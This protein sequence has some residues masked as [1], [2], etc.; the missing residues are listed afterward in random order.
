LPLEFASNGTD[1]PLIESILFEIE[2]S[3]K[4]SK[5]PFVNI[6]K[7]SYLKTEN[8]I[9]FTIGTIFQIQ[10]VEQLTDDICGLLN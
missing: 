9:L 7:Y 6:E 5:K 4:L 2:C 10:S 3:V 1:R 8:E